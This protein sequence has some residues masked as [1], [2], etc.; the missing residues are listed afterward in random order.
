MVPIGIS[1]KVLDIM[2]SGK[3]LD[4]MI[5]GS[6][7]AMNEFRVRDGRERT[8]GTVHFP[9]LQLVDRLAIVGGWAYVVC[10]N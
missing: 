7:L 4:V 2:A 10:Y 5:K 9:G 8:A 3:P 6:L 1:D